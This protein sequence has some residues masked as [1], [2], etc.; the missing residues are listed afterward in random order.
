MLEFYRKQ[1]KINTTF[2]KEL[3]ALSVSFQHRGF[4]TK[5]TENRIVIIIIIL[6]YTPAFSCEIKINMSFYV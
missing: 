5:D 2:V 4:E 6:L 1:K 3:K